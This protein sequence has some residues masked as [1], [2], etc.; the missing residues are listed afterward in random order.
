MKLF[1]LAKKHDKDG[2]HLIDNNAVRESIADWYC[3]A[4]GLKNTKLRT[5]SALS[6]GDTPGPEAS[7]TKI[8]SKKKLLA[9]GRFGLVSSVVSGVLLAVVSAFF[10]FQ[11][12]WLGAAGLCIAGGTGAFLISFVAVRVLGLPPGARAAHVLPFKDIPRRSSS[13][14]FVLSVCPPRKLPFFFSISPAPKV[15]IGPFIPPP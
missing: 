7:I 5:M 14:F 11:L 9:L 10:F 8:V 3:E 15:F 1:E 13:F 6:R 2:E 4:S 12:A